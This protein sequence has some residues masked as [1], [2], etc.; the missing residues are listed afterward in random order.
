MESNQN[1]K[2]ESRHPVPPVQAPAP[3]TIAPQPPVQPE[4]MIEEPVQLNK[5]KWITLDP[6][7]FPTVSVPCLL[8]N[9][10]ALYYIPVRVIEK[11]ILSHFENE[12]SQEARDFGQLSSFPCTFEEMNLL[13]DIND[14]HVDKLF[15]HE[16]FNESDIVVRLEQFLEFFKI[17]K[18]TVALKPTLAH[19]RNVVQLQPSSYYQANKP[20]I[21]NSSS[22]HFNSPYVQNV[23]P[24][25]QS[26]YQQLP[27][28]Q[29]LQNRPYMNYQPPQSYQIRHPINTYQYDVNNYSNY[30][31]RPHL[32]TSTPQQQF[33]TMTNNLQLNYQQNVYQNYQNLRRPQTLI[34]VNNYPQNNAFIRPTAA[35]PNLPNLRPSYPQQQVTQ[36]PA[37]TQVNGTSPPIQLLT[38]MTQLLQPAPVR[39]ASPVQVSTPLTIASN[40]PSS[41]PSPPLTLPIL[42]ELNQSS[43]SKNFTQE[44]IGLNQENN[45]ANKDDDDDIIILGD[46]DDEPIQP[47]AKKTAP[48]SQAQ[49]SV[50][51][52][53]TSSTTV[54]QARV[55]PETA[56]TAQTAVQQL[57]PQTLDTTPVQTS[58]SQ[59]N[60]RQVQPIILS[61]KSKTQLDSS[62]IVIDSLKQTPSVALL[63]PPQIHSFRVITERAS[64]PVAAAPIVSMQSRRSSDSVCIPDKYGLVQLNSFTFPFVRLEDHFYQYNKKFP[65][66]N[67]YVCSKHLIEAGLITQHD[68]KR[69]LTIKSLDKHEIKHMNSLITKHRL[70]FNQFDSSQCNQVELVN[71]IEFQFVYAKQAYFFK[72]LDENSQFEQY[73]SVLKSR[74]G[75]LLI[76]KIK[77]VIPFIQ[78]E[79]KLLVGDSLKY[80]LKEYGSIS[81]DNERVFYDASQQ[82]VIREFYQLILFYFSLDNKINN[83]SNYINLE[84]WLDKYSDDFAIICEYNENFPSE[85]RDD[86]DN[87]LRYLNNQKSSATSAQIES[88]SLTPQS[89]VSSEADALEQ[90]HAPIKIISCSILNKHADDTAAKQRANILIKR[91]RRFS[92]AVLFE[93]RKIS[94]TEI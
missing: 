1:V 30:Y 2:S 74:G 22:T 58:I 31:V 65:N 16:K 57:T 10:E 44:M 59:T 61:S 45:H 25:Q 79:N 53:S 40:P 17:L 76:K 92:D 82:T 54:Q 35:S 15:G 64:L 73:E 8:R 77:K 9:D 7:L 14:N 34:Q 91:K 28:I 41:N 70:N 37:L 80:F 48:Q 13:N 51:E 24:Q 39:P 23:Q 62:Q 6:E 33:Q 86:L 42:A 26:A 89:I 66:C 67:K 68:V 56:Q 90:E 29:S 32:T 78:L 72:V 18:R 63:V 94:N 27:N 3:V 46:D 60:V 93:K 19:T 4:P 47:S 69:N 84:K 5:W 50:Q 38:Q 36:R 88:A 75:L 55:Q 85:W 21:N 83:D 71:V 81:V 12:Y 49:S 87:Y 52:S 11:I 43:D 20:L